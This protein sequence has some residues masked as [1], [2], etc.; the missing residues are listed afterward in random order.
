MT[1]RKSNI[2]A[3]CLLA[4]AVLGCLSLAVG[5]AYARYREDV[6]STVEIGIRKNAQVYLVAGNDPEKYVPGPVEW[7]DSGTAREM[8]F[9]I[10][11]TGPDNKIPE[12]TQQCS[13]RLAASLDV[14]DGESA[15]S[16]KLTYT[17]D[18]KANVITG[19]ISRIQPDTVLYKEFGDGWLITF[20][21]ST[22]KEMEWKLEGNQR[23]TVAVHL[24]LETDRAIDCGMIQLL[25]EGRMLPE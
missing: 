1:G 21:D 22:D 7:E 5:V 2:S 23:S 11:N 15:L 3:W 9:L 16:V 12:A 20:P 14:W 6:G 10:S 18:K 17:Q 25:L 8:E 19:Q 4:L 13:L 24:T